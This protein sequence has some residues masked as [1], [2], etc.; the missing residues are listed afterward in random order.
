[1]EPLSA[2][3]FAANILQVINLAV[4]T[5]LRADTRIYELDRGVTDIAWCNETL[6]SLYAGLQETSG[7]S[8]IALSSLTQQCQSVG[9]EL[10]ALVNKVKSSNDGV[11]RR[12]FQMMKGKIHKDKMAKIGRKLSRLQVDI[13]QQVL[14][15]LHVA[16][17]YGAENRKLLDPATRTNIQ[18]ALEDLRNTRDPAGESSFP[19]VTKILKT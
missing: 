14:L 2:V 3:G 16:S 19:Y 7:P 17:S 5:S 13:S 18:L 15:Q 8:E 12:G 4:K 6:T 1:M 10:L 11:S 9:N